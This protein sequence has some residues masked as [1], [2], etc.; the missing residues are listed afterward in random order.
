MAYSDFAPPRRSRRRRNVIILVVALSVV[1]VLA[2][3]VRYRTERRES[4]D[5]LEAA[6]E[7]SRDHA[8]ISEQLGTLLQGLGG[9]DRPGLELRLETLE[10]RAQT[11]ADTLDEAVIPR[12][13][14]EVSGLLSVAT[15]S[16]SHGIADMREAILSILDAEESDGIGDVALRDAFDRLRVG[17]VAYSEALSAINELDPELL[18]TGFPAVSYTAGSY[19]PLYDATLVADRLR[20]LGTLAEV[21]D[22]ALVVTTDPEPVSGS[23]SGIW[24]IPASDSLSLQVRVSNT[25]NVVAENI[26]VLV[27]LQRVGSAEVIDPVSRLIPSIAQGESEIRTF[28]NLPAEPGVMYSLTATATVE[29]VDDPT[30]DNTRTLVFERNTP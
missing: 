5:Y 24:T 11:L 14:A 17:D 25:G 23:D 20:H 3:A 13:V 10:T 18:P 2:L 1:G 15:M 9:E 28:E 21:V 12:P 4:I 29:D 8:E 27:T 6:E 16:W 19:A 7:V 26:T 30:D 22:V